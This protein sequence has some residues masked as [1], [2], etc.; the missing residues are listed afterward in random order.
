MALGEPTG[1]RACFCPLHFNPSLFLNLRFFLCSR[2]HGSFSSSS[3]SPRIYH[4]L[5]RNISVQYLDPL[6]TLTSP[7]DSSVSSIGTLEVPDYPRLRLTAHM[8]FSQYTT[9]QQTPPML[10]DQFYLLPM[11][12]P[13]SRVVKNART[14]AFH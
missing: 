13:R 4:N 9:P 7:I 10:L 12:G 5:R 1:A 6:L 14:A 8:H 3:A 2:R 11:I